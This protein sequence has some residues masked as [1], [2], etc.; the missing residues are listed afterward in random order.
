MVITNAQML[1]I[2]A[3]IDM[4]IFTV[5][6]FI[7]MLAEIKA[8]IKASKTAT[9]DILFII[10]YNEVAKVLGLSPFSL[11]KLF[12]LL[13]TVIAIVIIAI[14]VVITVH[15]KKNP[16]VNSHCLPPFFIQCIYHSI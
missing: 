12:L 1:I 15:I 11:G 16:P 3:H 10:V 8:A 14:I 2:S 6:L 13:C 7:D 4:M 5:G 9:I